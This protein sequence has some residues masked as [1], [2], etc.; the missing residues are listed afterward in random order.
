MNG[1]NNKG[2]DKASEA[3]L[4]QGANLSQLEVL[5]AQDKRSLR[6]KLF[7]V[8]PDGKRNGTD[9]WLVSTVAPHL[10]KPVYD[11]EQYIRRMHHSELPPRLTSEFWKGQR[12]KQDYEEE[13]GDLWRTNDVIDV[14]N[15]LY[16]LVRM[17]II[18][19]P[20]QMDK[21][22]TLDAKQRE[23]VNS[24][25]DGLLEEMRNTI[26]REFGQRVKKDGERKAQQE[27]DEDL[28]DL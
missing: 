10:V 23:I 25:V 26:T 9:V 14:I 6:R 20:D 21:V 12:A 22:T 27:E 11:I 24:Q 3:I 17:T 7:N 18:L 16:R 8:K 4:Y 28:D 13:Q 15:E 5:F 19:L 1:Y 2:P